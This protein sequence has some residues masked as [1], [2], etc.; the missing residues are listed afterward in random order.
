MRSEQTVQ[1]IRN[2]RLIFTVTSG[3]SGTA[4]LTAVF[5]YMKGV[6][7]YHEPAPEYVTCL[8]QVQSQPELARKFLLEEKLPVIAADPAGIYVET[9]H[10]FCKGFVEP[11]LALDI[12]PDLVIHRRSMRDI[13]LSLYKM[14][15][16][17]GR[18][19]KALRFYLS[20]DDPNVLPLA[21]WQQL[22]DYQLC[23]WYCLEIERR[24]RYYKD[25]FISRGA[26]VSETTLTGLKTGRGLKQLLQE[27]DLSL[28]FPAWLMMLRFLRNSRFKVNES[29]ITK[30]NVA[31]PDRLDELEQEV[32]Q[33]LPSQDVDRW[34]PELGDRGNGR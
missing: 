21:N 31:V 4:Y 2:K 24:A 16:V 14:G 7:A 30:K 5:N 8:R 6:H 12:V 20:P 11:L 27:L 33:R 19:S 28:K 3:R 18:T 9:S 15:T 23:Y 25:L 26:R 32:L 1:Q 29:K 22:H 34:F 10:L 17:P 13:S